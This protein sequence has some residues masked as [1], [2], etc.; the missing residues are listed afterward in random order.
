[1]T[2]TIFIV[3]C[4]ILMGFGLYFQSQIVKLKKENSSLKT[5]H[6]EMPTETFVKML[7]NM[8]YP[9]MID[10]YRDD[11]RV[12]CSYYDTNLYA[13]KVEI[14]DLKISELREGFKNYV[15]AFD[16]DKVRQN[17]DEYAA[18]FIAAKC[19]FKKEQ[20]QL[21]NIIPIMNLLEPK[22]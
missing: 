21:F 16:P 12:A 9:I 18:D 5:K 15:K 7:P 6:Q 1:M 19:N 2:Y 10:E 8:I 13:S 20:I 14:K 3:L 11:L 4:F 17:H 22:Q